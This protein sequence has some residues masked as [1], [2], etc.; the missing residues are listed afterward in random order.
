MRYSHT[1]SRALIELDPNDVQPW[2]PTGTLPDRIYAA[3]KHRILTCALR[4]GERLLEREVC[5]SLQVSRTPLREA[6][7]RLALEGL[8]V[9]SPNRGCVVAPISVEDIRDLCELRQLVEVEAA[10]LA[11]QRATASDVE[12]LRSLAELRYRPGDRRTYED[13]LRANT[14]F[15]LAVVQCACNRRLES[16]VAS[17]LDQLQRPLYL[18][19]DLG[20]D[21]E[22]ETQEHLDLVAAIARHDPEAARRVRRVGSARTHK[23]VLAAVRRLLALDHKGRGAASPESRSSQQLR[24]APGREN[25][26]KARTPGR[27]RKRGRARAS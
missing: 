10:T 18:G 22:Q 7:N 14:A 20:L 27:R 4:P 21:A 5:A 25:A 3:L 15:H 11:A 13:Y 23:A 12:R 9:T 24:Y 8:V 19:L 26:T 16:I 2:K 6:L 17:L 1:R